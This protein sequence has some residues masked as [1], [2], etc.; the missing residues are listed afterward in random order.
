MRRF[1]A[2]VTPNVGGIGRAAKSTAPAESAPPSQTDASIKPEL[3]AENIVP[4]ETASENVQVPTE[5]VKGDP[6]VENVAKSELGNNSVQKPIVNPTVTVVTPS[7]KPDAELSSIEL[8]SV[9]LYKK[10]TSHTYLNTQAYESTIL[11][12]VPE[13]ESCHGK[14]SIEPVE[15]DSQGSAPVPRYLKS[16]IN[17]IQPVIK[18]SAHRVRTFSSASESEDEGKR[19]VR[20]PLIPVTKT[21]IAKE[22]DAA[23]AKTVE[24]PAKK[25]AEEKSQLEIRK[26]N[27]RKKFAKG[28]VELSKMTMFDLIYYNPDGEKPV[29]SKEKLVTRRRTIESEAV[30]KKDRDEANL[31]LDERLNEEEEMSKMDEQLAEKDYEKVTDD[32]QKK[33]EEEEEDDDDDDEQMAVPQVRLGPDGQIIIDDRSLVI[34]TTETKKNKIEMLNATVIVENGAGLVNYG[35][36]RKR[37]RSSRWSLRETARYYRALS[38]LGTD[39]SLMENLFPNRSRFELKRKFKVEEKVNQDLIDR[40]IASQ[41]P[42]D[43][44]VFGN[45]TDDDE[46]SDT[47]STTKEKNGQDKVK[48]AAPRR[49]RKKTEEQEGDEPKPKRKYVRKSKQVA[50]EEKAEPSVESS[51]KDVD[52]ESGALKCA[53]VKLYRLPASLEPVST[54]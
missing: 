23:S 33:C 29:R 51:A 35:S 19:N 18:G 32:Q 38:M 7:S 8:T 16:R 21:P 2:K 22:N 4:V 46:L 45:E 44:T 17:K 11:V 20:K 9:E 5:C 28:Q 31:L 36:W 12:P 41:K 50:D 39:F 52:C 47:E 3:K 1:R 49:R 10:D 43:P 13:S 26:E 25:K 34:E 30:S 37:K 27:M 24:P 53:V 14:K 15:S 40:T 54:C 42:F 6:A 48:K